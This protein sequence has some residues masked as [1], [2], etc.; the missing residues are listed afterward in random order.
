MLYI[1]FLLFINVIFGQVITDNS[2]NSTRSISLAGA[3]VSNPGKIESVFSNPANLSSSTKSSF[4]IGNT[5]FYEQKF[6]SYEYFSLLYSSSKKINFALSMQRLGTNTKDNDNMLSSEESISLSQGFTLLNDRNSSLRLGYNINYYVYKQGKTAGTSGDGSNGLSAKRILSYGIDLGILASLR[7][8]IIMGAFIKNIN[9]P[10]IGR[11]N[12]NQNLPRRMNIGFS[13]IPTSKLIT[14]FNYE[15][16]INSKVT[17]FRFGLEYKLHKFFTLRSGIQM[18]PNKIGFGFSSLVN[19]NI[20]LSYGVL[21]D[22][23]LPLTHS[24]ELELRY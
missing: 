8:K 24:F 4:L 9:S 7:D 6:L 3:T 19:D 13:Y 20:I 17:Q 22:P 1:C 11:N 10:T 12:N 5:N 15:K 23:I 14:M 2:F 18:K 16:N 21:T